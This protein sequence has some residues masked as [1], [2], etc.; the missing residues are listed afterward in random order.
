MDDSAASPVSSSQLPAI[1][2]R[3]AF[4]LSCVDESIVW[5]DAHGR[6]QWC[7]AAFERLVNQTAAALAEQL[8]A[9]VLPLTLEG[10]TVPL[11]LHP[12]NWELATQQ[13]EG[14][15]G[16]CRHDRSFRLA[17][18]VAPLPYLEDDRTAGVMLVIRDLTTQ[19][20]QQRLL[21]R[22]NLELEEAVRARTTELSA[23]NAWVTN[24]LESITDAFYTLDETWCFTYINHHA[25][26]LLQRSRAELLGKNIWAWFPEA[27][28]SSFHTEFHRAT[29]TQCSIALEAFYPP[30]N[31]WFDV[32][33]YPI[34]KGLA[35]YFQDISDRKRLE[36]ERQQT[37][38]AL[39]ESEQ[40]F[41]SLFDTTAVGVTMTTPDG[42]LLQANAAYCQMLGY[43]QPELLTKTCRQLIDRDDFE[44]GLEPLRKLLAGELS[45]Y[46]TERRYFHKKGH[47]VWGLVSMS[48]VRGDLQQPLYVVYQVQDITERQAALHERKQ[49]EAALSESEARLKLA[50]EAAQMNTWDWNILTNEVVYSGYINSGFSLPSGVQR[51]AYETFLQE[52]DPDDR[53]D[54]GDAL[55]RALD[56]A[57]YNVE[58]RVTWADGT[59]RWVC[60]K[61]K[62]S[63][64]QQ[65]VP[66][67]MLGVL[68]D[69]TAYKQ[70]E[71]SLQQLNQELEQRVQ[72]RTAQLEQ[73]NQQLQ[74][75]IVA[76]ERTEAA[77]RKSEER[78]RIIFDCAPIAITLADAHTYRIVDV[79]Q[80][81]HAL[82]GYSHAELASM[83][84]IDMT[85]PDDVGKNL[86]QIKQLLDGTISRFQIEKRFVK[87]NGDWIWANLTV[88]LIHDPDGCAYSMGMIEDIT[89]RKRAEEALRN[90]QQLLQL[91]IDSVPSTIFWKDKN[92]RYLGCN[93]QFAID[94]GLATPK[95]IIGKNDFELPWAVHAERC[96]VEDL[97]V[98]TSNQPT[99]AVE[100]TLVKA[101]GE[102]R[103][104]KNSKVPLH[105]K[106]GSAIGILGTYEDITERRQVDQ[107]LR[108]TQF[109]IDRASDPIWW[110]EP[111][112]TLC[113]VNDAA[114]R[115]L[116]YTHD[117]MIG[118]QVSDFNKDRP[119]AAWA[120][121]WQT[122]KEQGAL[123]FEARLHA[124][125]GTLFPVEVTANH[126]EL[127]G[128][129]YHCSFVRNI[130]ARK[131]AEDKLKAS[132]T[133]KEVLLKEIHHRVKNNL[134]MVCSL[135]NLQANTIQDP[136]V[137]APFQDSQRRIKA[138]A[139]VHERLD[140]SESLANVNF[141]D[142]VRH[143]VTDLIHSCSTDP[144]K[145]NL[146]LEIAQLELAV[147]VAIPC[148]LII[149]ELVTNALKYAFPDD[150]AGE[151][152][153]CFSLTTAN[154][155]LLVVADDGVGFLT[156]SSAL[157]H[158]PPPHS[159]GLQLVHAFVHQLRGTI[160][161]DCS[162]GTRFELSFP[163]LTPKG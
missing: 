70:A 86:D 149:N 147:N 26:Q 115:D 126:I 69:I 21:Q 153:I 145:I 47:V 17:I 85:H 105:D 138:M 101:G 158:T 97:K 92:L 106:N 118:K 96:Q 108:L 71:L 8:L 154:Q 29:E 46:H 1:V 146:K 81:H 30:F 120:D 35:V 128:K 68:R 22:T 161:L 6:I 83:T 73:T 95:D 122:V 60:S 88:A 55:A 37:E 156:P 72:G 116:G 42:L 135:L 80:A 102:Q 141:S 18:T 93:H 34:A 27:I 5:T 74:V 87:K 75:S 136:K 94:A 10:D 110:V 20:V 7:N 121:H 16:F 142:Y 162:H 38:A 148:S 62:T 24:I 151:I 160:E 2:S 45:A 137:L 103:W 111:D 159:L 56:G 117:E 130:T 133:E 43:T 90:N 61:G 50:L 107:A 76:H 63:F 89:D 51:A 48:V 77:L 39:R 113:Y 84:Y 67:R 58:F 132:L 13:R 155:Y 140:Q 36:L 163:N 114:C 104:I 59:Q 66:V 4:A 57:D 150:R 112:G 131:Q 127:N 100:E 144:T 123:T 15:Y 152:Q 11:S 32:R 52:V 40:W 129:E 33:A 65:G 28:D 41:R 49:A 157:N 9:E 3:M 98:M 143:L 124:K 64:D 12:V 25:E 134:Q 125:D 53:D 99:L 31:A 14:Q 19:L 78:F 109:S 139:L 44:R 54:V 79:N 119:D 91:V 23:T 82:L